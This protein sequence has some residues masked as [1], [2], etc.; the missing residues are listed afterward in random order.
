MRLARIAVRDVMPVQ[1]CEV[2]ELADAVVRPAREKRN[3]SGR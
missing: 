2:D 3:E 1:Q